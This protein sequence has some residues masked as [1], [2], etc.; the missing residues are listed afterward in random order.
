MFAGVMAGLCLGPV[1]GFDVRHFLI[2]RLD[3]VM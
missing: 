3:S 1:R 2:T